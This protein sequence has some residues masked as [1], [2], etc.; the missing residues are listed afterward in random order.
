MKYT[1]Y[2]EKDQFADLTRYSDGIAWR[3]GVIDEKGEEVDGEGDLPDFATARGLALSTLTLL[4]DLNADE[5][6]QL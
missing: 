5:Q 3:S 2:I 4:T 1:I 6:K